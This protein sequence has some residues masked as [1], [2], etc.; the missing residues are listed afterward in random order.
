MN[1]SRDRGGVRLSIAAK[2][3]LKLNAG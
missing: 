2:T 3:V 1:R